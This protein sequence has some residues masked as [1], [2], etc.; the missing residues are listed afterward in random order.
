MQT[1]HFSSSVRCR[2]GTRPA[3]PSVPDQ[4]TLQQPRRSHQE[5]SFNHRTVKDY[6][7]L[8]REYRKWQSQFPDPIE[9]IAGLNEIGWQTPAE[10]AFTS[11]LTTNQDVNETLSARHRDIHLVLR[12][13]WADQLQLIYLPL[14]E[15]FQQ[16]K[17]GHH[18]TM[19]HRKY[20]ALQSDVDRAHRQLF[21]TI[22][23]PSTSKGSFLLSADAAAFHIVASVLVEVMILLGQPDIRIQDVFRILSRR[24]P[25][26]TL[27]LYHRMVSTAGTAQRYSLVDWLWR[28]S[29]QRW[30]NTTDEWMLYARARAYGGL[31]GG[32][33]LKLSGYWEL[34]DKYNPAPPAAYGKVLPPAKDSKLFPPKYLFTHILLHQ[35]K[36]A[37]QF[38]S[39]RIGNCLD[40]LCAMTDHGY[41]ID[42]GIWHMILKTS[43]S[44][45]LQIP[46]LMAAISDRYPSAKHRTNSSRGSDDNILLTLLAQRAESLDVR[47]VYRILHIMGIRI[48][49]RVH[50]PNLDD[51]PSESPSSGPSPV[52]HAEKSTPSEP[53]STGPSPVDHI[54]QLTA[55]SITAMMLGRLGHVQRAK[56]CLQRCFQLRD[57]D[58]DESSLGKAA[59]GVMAA[60]DT[61][62]QSE[63]ALEFGKQLMGC[64][65]AQPASSYF[66][67]S[68]S[69]SSSRPISIKP[70]TF[71]LK[72]M[73]RSAATM[74]DRLA[75]LEEGLWIRRFLNTCG[76]KFDPNIARGLV[77][78][79]FGMAQRRW[80]DY[81]GIRVIVRELRLRLDHFRAR[82]RRRPCKILLLPRI[83]RRKLT[84]VQAER[85]EH[86]LEQYDKTT[87]GSQSLI[88]ER[89]ANLDKKA[90]LKRHVRE[91]K[92]DPSLEP[93]WQADLAFGRRKEEEKP[94]SESVQSS[95]DPGQATL[96]DVSDNQSN[97]SDGPETPKGQTRSAYAMRL[98]ILAVLLHDHEGA[99]RLLQEMVDKGLRPT[100]YH[101]APIVEG[102]CTDGRVDEAI[103]FA[104]VSRR[105]LGVLTT[106]RCETAQ[107][108]GLIEQGRRSDAE[109][110]LQEWRSSGGRA[111]E[112]MLALFRIDSLD[113][114]T[115]TNAESLKNAVEESLRKGKPLDR[116]DVFAAY[117]WMMDHWMPLSAQSLIMRA[118]QTG[119][120]VEGELRDAI[121]TAGNW[122]KKLQFRTQL[123]EQIYLEEQGDD[124][125]VESQQQQAQDHT[126]MPNR[127]RDSN[128]SNAPFEQDRVE[129]QDDTATRPPARWRD[130]DPSDAPSQAES[131]SNKTKAKA[132]AK[133]KSQSE[134]D[135]GA[136]S[137][138]DSALILLDPN[139]PLRLL[140]PLHARKGPI[141]DR[142]LSLLKRYRWKNPEE[143]PGAL[144]EALRMHKEVLYLTSKTAHPRMR[145]EFRA[146]KKYRRQLM[147]MLDEYLHDKPVSQVAWD[148]DMAKMG[149]VRE[150]AGLNVVKKRRQQS[151]RGRGGPRGSASASRRG[152]TPRRGRGDKKQ[153][154]NKAVSSDASH[155]PEPTQGEVPALN[156]EAAPLLEQS[157]AEF[158]SSEITK[159]EANSSAAAVA[160]GDD[161]N[162]TS[163]QSSQRP[164][165][166]AVP[167]NDEDIVKA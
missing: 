117:R 156:S 21:D 80:P 79:F 126:P 41:T 25:A 166:Q 83:E 17:Q 165:Q 162:A 67:S 23:I 75:G 59:T 85:I 157:K 139:S 87:P 61:S 153:K 141:E 35:L 65:S 38:N 93:Y 132:K 66:P 151:G 122:I 44:L 161:D 102:L 159:G 27:P 49:R 30:S 137:S 9:A 53:P 16:L 143:Q 123:E 36:H 24:I 1:R 5:D 48:S 8:N 32:S 150:T 22:P 81:H 13:L 114:P 15:A 147:R 37:Q 96:A 26:F 155:H 64:D 2:K 51:K 148:R 135:K 103:R 105:V 109:A 91:S 164:G 58:P 47:D 88:H 31:P 125:H 19:S 116:E 28:H 20:S 74:A 40:T 98:R 63:K 101:V 52:K 70:T 120:I 68:S 136:S 118:V 71:L 72:T 94:A 69:S 129:A 29:S 77:S 104:Q 115:L 145:A 60:Y 12:S 121:V 43:P 10:L 39:P 90:A 4:P 128:S 134:Q 3:P 18:T 76:L 112:Y 158:D 34:Y 100:M 6:K 119:M 167:S 131:K 54:E 140:P 86:I 152:H 42:R 95:S 163:Q 138:T 133:S 7:T 92:T 130:S 97:T 113:L 154:E 55:L 106:A 45:R 160:A 144:A 46:R 56:D 111:D 62:G 73:L 99:L 127:W 33:L 149:R 14:Y 89:P 110:Q 50:K 78:F 107:L 82:T 84:P 108:R 142:D 146:R 124:G 11:R 57:S